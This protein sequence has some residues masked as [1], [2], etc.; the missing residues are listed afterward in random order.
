[1]CYHLYIISCSSQTDTSV[2]TK[3]TTHYTEQHYQSLPK[4]VDTTHR[5]TCLEGFVTNFIYATCLKVKP[6]LLFETATKS[7]KVNTEFLR[8]LK[9]RNLTFTITILHY[10]FQRNMLK[11]LI[12]SITSGKFYHIVRCLISLYMATHLSTHIV[13][14][15]FR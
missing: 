15:H 10:S 7:H 1:M 3:C 9:Y 13:K 2:L 5:T 4:S 14:S 8:F 6:V 12:Q 11:F